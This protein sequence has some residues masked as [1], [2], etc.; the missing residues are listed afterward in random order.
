MKGSDGLGVPERFLLDSCEAKYVE[1]CGKSWQYVPQSE[2][3][4]QPATAAAAQS[5]SEI[6][7]SAAVSRGSDK[8]F[9][10]STI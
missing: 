3:L 9:V 4:K 1:G 7:N 8:T 5:S 2:C 10:M 6:R